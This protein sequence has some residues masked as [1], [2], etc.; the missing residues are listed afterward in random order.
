MLDYA[1]EKELITQINNG[2]DPHQATAELVGIGRREAKTISFGLIYGMG[3]QKLADSLGLTYDAAK[4]LKHKYF[5]RLPKTKQLIYGVSDAAKARG[6]VTSWMGRR[7]MFPNPDFAYK[8]PNALIQGGCADVTKKAMVST[9]EA[10]VGLITQI[11]MPVHDELVLEV[12][13]GEED[14]L[15]MVRK[16]MEDS[17]PHKL[18]PLTT[19]I[20]I[21]LKSLCDADMVEVT[22]GNIGEEIRNQIQGKSAEMLE[23]FAKDLVRENST[24][25][26]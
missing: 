11:I 16:C 15:G 13:I 14:L 5:S 4:A 22:G 24:T 1:G 6:F 20:A 10:L 21:S 7:F 2:L 18:I 3:I 23:G 25:V 12:A 26:H 8:S 19:S 17:Y 9:H